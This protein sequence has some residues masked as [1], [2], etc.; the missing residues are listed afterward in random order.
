MMYSKFG[1]VLAERFQILHQKDE[2]LSGKVK[3]IKP[4]PAVSSFHYKSIPLDIPDETVE[5]ESE[6]SLKTPS[7]DLIKPKNSSSFLCQSRDDFYKSTDKKIFSPAFNYY[8]C[9]YSLVYKSVRIPKFKPRPRTKSRRQN[10]QQI[11]EITG[12]DKPKN[13]IQSPVPFEVQLSRPEITSLT[14]DVNENRFVG[15][16]D[17]PKNY[18]KY[19][20]VSTPSMQKT[21]ERNE[22]FKSNTHSPD[23]KPSFKLVTKDLGKVASFDK[24]PARKHHSISYKNDTRYYNPNYA[25]IEKKITAPDFSKSTSRPS[26]ANALPCFMKNVNWRGALDLINEKSLEMNYNIEKDS[27]CNSMIE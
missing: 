1:K 9:K 15:Y 26:S 8:D 17:M 12:C 13:R 6:K 19:K 24:Y 27:V 21:T 22:L 3:K 5:E 23:Y 14:K 11:S 2:I 4:P 20:R 25:L 18:S 16:Q 10:S 7:P